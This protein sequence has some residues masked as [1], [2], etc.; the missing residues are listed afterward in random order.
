MH[1]VRFFA[2]FL[3]LLLLIFAVQNSDVVS[4]DF[5]HW[6]FRG[7]LAFVLVLSFIAGVLTGVFSLLPVLWKKMK[8]GRNSRKRVSELEREIEDIVKRR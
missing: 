6:E 4:I 8:D 7:S 3:A 1:I 5:I 2:L